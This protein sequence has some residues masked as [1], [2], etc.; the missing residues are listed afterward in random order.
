[1]AGRYKRLLDNADAAPYWQYIA[2]MDGRTRH[3]HAELNGKIWRFDDPIWKVIWPPNGFNCRCRVTALS[4]AQLK[5]RG[6]TPQTTDAGDFV[7]NEIVINRAGDTL[8]VRGIKLRLNGK[9]IIFH[10]DPGWDGNPALAADETLKAWI[11]RKARTVPPALRPLYLE[12]AKNVGKDV[13]SIAVP[14]VAEAAERLRQ[15]A[16]LAKAEGDARAWVIGMGIKN[17]REYLVAYDLETGRNVFR[18]EGEAER[19][20]VDLGALNAAAG[21]G[22]TVRLVHN[23]PASVSL[24]LADLAKLELPAVAEVEA[25]GIDRISAYL[26]RSAPRFSRFSTR[27]QADLVDVTDTVF[28]KYRI[29][30][31]IQSHVLNLALQQA[32]MIAYT[33]RLSPAHKRLYSAHSNVDAAIAEIA[34]FLK[35]SP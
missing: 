3:T 34:A 21:R 14:G 23:H 31:E 12:Q 10:P 17:N 13:A 27:L 8:P 6:I 20:R 9:E 2:V 4:E 32:G 24:S 15:A 22:E 16:R 18:M 5:E 7:E 35:R 1:M 26:A 11:E 33:F 29:P 25:V 19:V 30:F 28:D